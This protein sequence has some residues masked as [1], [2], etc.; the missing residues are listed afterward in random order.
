MRAQVVQV[1]GLGETAV[2]DAQQGLRDLGMDSLMAVELRNRLQRSV[3]RALPSTV[4]FDCPTV[5]ALTA[6]LAKDV[7]NLS[8]SDQPSRQESQGL[9]AAAAPAHDEPIAI[10]GMGLRLPGDADT[11]EKYWDLLRHGVDAIS[12]VP[13]DRWDIDEYYDPDPARPG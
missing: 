13:A 9:M 2:L 4:A 6:Y 11:P 1:L 12:E 10:V 7:L 8:L 5:E 3:G